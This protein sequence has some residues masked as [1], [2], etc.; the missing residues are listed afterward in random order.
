MVSLI[1]ADEVTAFPAA[2]AGLW[3]RAL[4]FLW[5]CASNLGVARTCPA[6]KGC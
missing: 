3:S 5:H 1:R 4:R 6:T 2:A